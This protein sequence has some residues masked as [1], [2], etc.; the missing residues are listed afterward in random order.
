[1]KVPSVIVFVGTVGSGK[2]TQMRL[3][4]EH[5]RSKGFKVKV[6]WLKV[7]N[8]WAYPLYKIA[9][10]GCPIFRNKFLFKLWI[11]LDILAVSLKFLI[12]IW[13]PFKT[14]HIVLIEEYL[15]A[16]AADYIHIARINSCPLKDVMTTIAYIYRLAVLMPFTSVFLDANNTILRKRWKARGTLDEKTEYISMQRK[17]LLPLTKLLSHRLIYID[18][19]DS[20]VKEINHR[21][22]NLMSLASP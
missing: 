9:L 12:S 4:A 21:L 15:P 10:M 1:M 17:L 11:V 5:L 13:L 2:S 19:S 20:A 18:T 22:E 16:V 7:G 3:L 14:G 8:L 6:T